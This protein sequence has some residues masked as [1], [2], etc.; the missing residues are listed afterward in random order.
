MWCY[1]KLLFL[2]FN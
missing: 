2:A 1:F